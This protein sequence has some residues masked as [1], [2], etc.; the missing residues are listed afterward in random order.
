MAKWIVEVTTSIEIEADTA[1]DAK[2]AIRCCYPCYGLEGDGNEVIH[3]PYLKP[4]ED[5]S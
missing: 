1:E 4:D 5:G 2:N 3:E